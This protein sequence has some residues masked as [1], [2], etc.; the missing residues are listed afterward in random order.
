MTSNPGYSEDVALQAG[1]N[2]VHIELHV[3]VIQRKYVSIIGAVHSV[4]K[5]R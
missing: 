1:M 2:S 3:N 5:K 4:Y